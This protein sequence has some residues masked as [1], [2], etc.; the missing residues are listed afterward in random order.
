MILVYIYINIDSILYIFLIF[1]VI[2]IFVV[3]VLV[4]FCIILVRNGMF[5]EKHKSSY[6]VFIF[7][8]VIDSMFIH[9]WKK[10]I[11]FWPILVMLYV[12]SS[13]FLIM[14]IARGV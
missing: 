10:L 13:L 1:S 11:K 9:S 6:L 3:I 7:Y 2:F 8:Y 5:H 4:Q 14:I 12:K